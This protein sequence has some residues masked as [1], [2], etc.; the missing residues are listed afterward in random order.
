MELKSLLNDISFKMAKNNWR[1]NPILFFKRGSVVRRSLFLA[2]KVFFLI[3]QC[4][5]FFFIMKLDK[6]ILFL[7]CNIM[8]L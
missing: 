6:M 8:K 7:F 1:K 5:Y 4:Y 3:H 2:V